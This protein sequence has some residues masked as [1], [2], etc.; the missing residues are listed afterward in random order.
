MK[1]FNPYTFL[2]SL[3]FLFLLPQ[4]SSAQLTDDDPF[5]KVPDIEKQEGYLILQRISGPGAAEIAII[6]TWN[7]DGVWCENR[8]ILPDKRFSTNLLYVSGT[9]NKTNWEHHGEARSAQLVVYGT[10]SKTRKEMLAGMEGRNP[11]EHA[12]RQFLGRGMDLGKFLTLKKQG[13][14]FIAKFNEERDFICQIEKDV[15]AALSYKWS[16]RLNTMEKPVFIADVQLKQFD[17]GSY[18]PSKLKVVIDRGNEADIVCDYVLLDFGLK[19]Y[20]ESISPFVNFSNYLPILVEGESV[21]NLVTKKVIPKAVESH[22]AGNQ[23]SGVGTLSVIIFGG[24]N[25]L[26]LCFLISAL[27]G[28]QNN[29][30]PTA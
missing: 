22:L 19:C 21:I 26:L 1:V 23:A 9:Y 6:Y 10:P 4:I 8:R 7:K 3:L 16:Y 29:K 14:N 18:I 15:Q 2:K 20:R 28:K 27:K 25:F 11:E 5:F 13:T 30:K 24:L 12:L 17:G